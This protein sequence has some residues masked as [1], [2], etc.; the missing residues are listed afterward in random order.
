MNAS[1]FRDQQTNQLKKYL[2]ATKDNFDAQ[3]T[4]EFG[5]SAQ[6]ITFNLLMSQILGLL[7]RDF[8]LVFLSIFL[9][10]SWFC[11]HLKSVFLALVGMS[12]IFLSFPFTAFIV[13]GIFRVSYFGYL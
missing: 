1:H 12:I 4:S 2:Q 7:F 10:F 9:V 11:L 13:S 3:D 5:F 6:Y 8:A